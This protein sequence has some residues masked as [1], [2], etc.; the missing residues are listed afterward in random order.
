MT[1][2]QLTPTTAAERQAWLEDCEHLKSTIWM[3]LVATRIRRLIADVERL[4]ADLKRATGPWTVKAHLTNGDYVELPTI[5]IGH[6]NRIILVD[7]STLK[8]RQAGGKA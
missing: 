5:D 1:D 6:S 4:E 2:T 7:G 3:P 8:A